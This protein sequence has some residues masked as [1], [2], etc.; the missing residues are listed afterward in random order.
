M[1]RDNRGISR[2][3]EFVIMFTVFIV[4]V[5]AFYSLASI[6]LRPPIVNYNQEEAMSS[7][8]PVIVSDIPGVREVIT[9]NVEVSLFRL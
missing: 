2:I 8:K 6:W 4:I 5:T 1:R 9:D 7:G 3:V